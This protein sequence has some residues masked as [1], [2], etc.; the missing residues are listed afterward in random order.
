MNAQIAPW[1]E[2]GSGFYRPGMAAPG[3]MRDKEDR[4][5]VAYRCVI[6]KMR[7][8]R[9]GL[10][11]PV[12]E[13]LLQAPV[14]SGII[15]TDRFTYPRWH[16]EAL[17]LPE[18]SRQLLQLHAVRLVRMRGDFR[19]YQGIQYSENARESWLQTWFCAPNEEAGRAVL[20]EMEPSA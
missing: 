9:D 16:A 8:A 18:L 19:Q 10:K 2:P 3:T 4:Q 11:L 15:C 13:V 12:A 14:I 6:F 7:R 1:F 5:E 20:H 17:A